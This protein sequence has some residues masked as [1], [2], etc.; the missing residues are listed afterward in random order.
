MNC[1]VSSGSP[2]ATIA[3]RIAAT[4]T[5]LERMDS[6][7]PFR[8]TALPDFSATAAASVVTFGRAS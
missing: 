3:L 1:T 4:R 6:E 7:P 8:M 5:R 2:A